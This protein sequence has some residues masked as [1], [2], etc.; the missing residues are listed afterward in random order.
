MRQQEWE[1]PRPLFDWGLLNS[2]R[3]HSTGH[4]S[5]Q[6][7]ML[8]LEQSL[9]LHGKPGVYSRP[10]LDLAHCYENLCMPLRQ[11]EH[12]HILAFVPTSH[13][14]KPSHPPTPA[15]IFVGEA[16]W[17]HTSKQKNLAYWVHIRNCPFKVCP[18]VPNGS[19][20]NQKI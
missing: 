15:V 18:L 9:M 11:E 3:L 10:F 8:L 13:A 1:L 12:H 6:Y 17:K 14:P 5:V 20:A 4:L 7:S 16:V 2:Q 19:W